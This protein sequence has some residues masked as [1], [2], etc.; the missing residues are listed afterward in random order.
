[1]RK[2]LPTFNFVA[3]LLVIIDVCLIDFSL[4]LVH[5]WL[6]SP[7][8]TF[9]QHYSSFYAVFCATWLVS[10]LL[11]RAYQ[12]ERFMQVNIMAKDL[13]MTYAFHLT[14]IVIYV[15]NLNSEIYIGFVVAV[16]ALS[17]CLTFVFRF[18]YINFVRYYKQSGI[19]DTKVIVI[20]TTSAGITL[21]NYFNSYKSFGYKFMGFFDQRTRNNPYNHLIKGGI[22]DVQFY[23][24]KENIDEIF[25]AL[26]E[27]TPEFIEE[28]QKFADANFI[29]L[30]IV[31]SEKNRSSLSENI[32]VFVFDNINV[33][34]IR[35]EPLSSK[36]NQILKRAFDIIFS[37]MVIS[38]IFPWLFPI[39]ALLIKLEDPAGP[40]F[41]VQ[42]RPGRKNKPFG[43]YKFR[44]MRVNTQTDMQATKNDS[45]ITKIGGFLRKTSLDELPQ[46]FNVLLG[47]M[48]VVG[49]RPNMQ[50]HLEE[51]SKTINNYQF[52]HFVT[53]GI[54]GYAQV[55]GYRGETKE[56]HLME[57]RVEYDV[58][59]MEKWSLFLDI[60]IIFL[61]V[62]NAIRGEENA[63]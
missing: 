28:L 21:Y 63:Y 33:F 39:V 25:V 41:F 58:K 23:C 51:Y 8:I 1:M 43:C 10:T 54:T 60:K 32:N 46:F 50:K 24:K 3:F 40:V 14:V 27:T 44:S 9:N 55:S 6:V 38:L 19:N 31:F 61:T 11:N 5:Y 30:R 16:Y 35:H 53:P 7:E 47:D 52:R 2:L 22:E 59:Y 29:Y 45:R 62:W 48:S 56:H 57:K 17:V 42:K 13:M 26:E 36:L 34:S 4:R 18:L 37:F 49:P 20:G 12:I 15:L